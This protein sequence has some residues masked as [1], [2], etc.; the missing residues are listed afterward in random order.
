MVGD[1]HGDRVAVSHSQKGHPIYGFDGPREDH[2]IFGFHPEKGHPVCASRRPNSERPCFSDKR[3][4]N[5]RCRRHGGKS[6]RGMAHPNFKTGEH[7]IYTAPPSLLADY[8][9]LKDHPELIEHR[10]SIALLDATINELL[11]EY[12]EGGGKKA[13]RDVKRIFKKVELA[14]DRE[15]R[16]GLAQGLAELGQAIRAGSDRSAVRAEIVGLVDARRKA[17]NSEF[18]REEIAAQTYT[19]EQMTLM[20][21]AVGLIAGRYVPEELKERFMEEYTEY[22]GPRLRHRHPQPLPQEDEHDAN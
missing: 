19:V 9:R 10:A 11:G 2:P 21:Q 4:A 7:S 12:D 13:W 16:E 20:M 17:V 15:D 6:R 14:W 3:M 18:K 8:D 22:I 5:G 1:V